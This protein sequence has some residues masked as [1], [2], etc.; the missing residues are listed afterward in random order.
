MSQQRHHILISLGSNIERELHT[1]A[2]VA[3]LQ[4]YFSDVELSSVYESEAVG[5]TGTAFY[6]L[7][8]S[9][10][11]DMSIAQVC[12]T[13]KSIERENG[14]VSAEKKF[15]PRTLDLDL[16][17]Y[18]Q[19]VTAEPVVLPRDEITYN[20]FVLQPL[21]ELVPDQVHPTTKK[22][23]ADLWQSYDKSLQNL[24]P[25]KFIWS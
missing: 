24:W 5:F 13:L 16:L 10:H 7:V 4:H 6:N 22:T 19:E 12:Q 11:T 15:A 23:Y 21:A 14:R 25:I 2:G 9:A 8:A 3:A 17:T 18:D 20:A 1:R